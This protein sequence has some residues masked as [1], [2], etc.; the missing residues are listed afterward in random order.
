MNKVPK[1]TNIYVIFGTVLFIRK[2]LLQVRNY[3]KKACFS[4]NLF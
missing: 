2:N 1:I 4:A 3:M